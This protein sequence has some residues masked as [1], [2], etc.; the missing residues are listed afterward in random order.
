MKSKSTEQVTLR[1][2]KTNLLIALFCLLFAIGVFSNL[3]ESYW[4]VVLFVLLVVFTFAGVK[5]YFAMKL[6]LSEQ[7]ILYD[8][9]LGKWGKRFSYRWEEIELEIPV[10]TK[11]G[12]FFSETKHR[13]V[14][15]VVITHMLSKERHPIYSNDFERPYEIASLL[16]QYKENYA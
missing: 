13:R 4:N 12:I 15:I 16:K 5:N 11:T 7:G 6:V 3:Q 10:Q 1:P 14:P 2:R 8:A 9:G